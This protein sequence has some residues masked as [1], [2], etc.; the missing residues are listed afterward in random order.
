MTARA[1]V[2]DSLIGADESVFESS[3]ASLHSSVVATENR[4]LLEFLK[5]A[6]QL[7]EWIFFLLSLT[8]PP[9]IKTHRT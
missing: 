4:E 5:F 1:V 9:P 6:W 2:A 8:L 3:S 7:D